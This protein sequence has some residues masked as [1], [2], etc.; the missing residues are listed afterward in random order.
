MNTARERLT[1]STFSLPLG[2]V[3]ALVGGAAT[4]R[5]RHQHDR[6]DMGQR[7]PAQTGSLLRRHMLALVDRPVA[8]CTPRFALVS[9]RGDELH[10]CLKRSLPAPLEHYGAIVR[11]LTTFYDRRRKA[12]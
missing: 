11:P 8:P 1:C 9:A 6:P 5:Q 10:P 2:E 7:P 12:D 4:A 3:H